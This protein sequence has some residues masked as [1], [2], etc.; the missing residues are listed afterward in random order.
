MSGILL[1]NFLEVQGV[2]KA[3]LNFTAPSAY[4]KVIMTFTYSKSSGSI[5]IDMLN[6]A[7]NN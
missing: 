6:L 2:K 7:K 1:N 3:T 4:T 5:W